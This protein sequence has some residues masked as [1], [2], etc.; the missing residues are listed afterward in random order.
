MFLC[1]HR[2]VISL[3]SRMSVCYYTS[4][5]IFFVVADQLLVSATECFFVIANQ[6]LV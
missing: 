5:A 3:S 6:S 4:V 1:W 2:L